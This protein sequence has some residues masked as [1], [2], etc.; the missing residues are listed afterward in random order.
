MSSKS[1]P[2]HSG[3]FVISNYA[4]D[5]SVGLVIRGPFRLPIRV[6][7]DGFREVWDIE[8]VEG[9]HFLFTINNF[10]TK[11]EGDSIWSYD[12]NVFREV[13]GTEWI[14]ER[15]EGANHYTITDSEGKGWT[16][17]DGENIVTLEPVP[18]TG[19][20]DTQLWFFERDLEE[21]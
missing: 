8:R 6:T 9:K 1:Y 3:R 7:I 20:P 4:R 12:H 5:K 2:L 17:K 15:K 13:K 21:I 14:V 19:V 18:D 11:A 10:V 16:L